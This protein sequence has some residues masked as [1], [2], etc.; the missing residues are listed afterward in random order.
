MGDKDALFNLKQKFAQRPTHAA[1]LRNYEFITMTINSLKE[2]L[3]QQTEEREVLYTYLFRQK[4]F[5]TRVRP[6]VEQYQH[7]FARI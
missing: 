1:V 7:K 4:T 6:I 2:Q 3:E 5:L